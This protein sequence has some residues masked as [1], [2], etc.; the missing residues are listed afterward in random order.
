MSTAAEAAAAELGEL[1]L[2]IRAT[3]E[4]FEVQVLEAPLR[5]FAR[6]RF[7]LPFSQGELR[8]FWK[9]LWDRPDDETAWQ[10]T[11]GRL[12]E[13]VFQGDVGQALERAQWETDQ[14]LRVRLVFHAQDE[15]RLL[16]LVPWEGL[17]NEADRRFLGTHRGMPVVR[18]ID[19]G[20][21]RRR[22]LTAPLPLR[23]LPVV[24]APKDQ[25]E[26]P[27]EIG[28]PALRAGLA[29]MLDSGEAVVLPCPRACQDDLRDA[30]LDTKPH[31]L[32]FLGHGG[33]EGDK[34][35]LALERPDGNSDLVDGEAFTRLLQDVPSLRLVVLTSCQTSLFGALPFVSLTAAAAVYTEV[36]A[37]IAMQSFLGFEAAEVFTRTL[38][39][40][41]AARDVLDVAMSEARSAMARRGSQWL[42]PA[43][44]MSSPDGRL[45][46]PRAAQ[47]S[48]PA[49]LS[50][51]VPAAPARAAAK[52]AQPPL[53]LGVRSMTPHS[54]DLESATDRQLSLR[55]FF[56]RRD[57]KDPRL[58]HEAIYPRLSEFLLE[59]ASQHR[60]LELYFAAHH[61][62]TFAAGWVLQ[63][64]SGLDVSFLQGSR[65]GPPEPW[66]PRD[67]SAAGDGPLWLETEET[68]ED[69][70]ASDVAIAM[71]LTHPIASQVAA[72]LAAKGPPVHRLLAAEVAPRAGQQA[73]R[74]GAHCLRLAD[75]IAYQ[76]MQRTPQE[77]RGTLH[78][79]TA[80]PNAF[81]FYLG[82]L[83]R[84]F[85][86]IQLY[87]YGFDETR[88][89]GE[90]VPSLVLPPPGD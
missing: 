84:P 61:T 28:E 21:R 72:H 29:S 56:D 45:V 18:Q 86:R 62:I 43:L 52:A 66:G 83:A 80:A 59:A 33:F 44:F 46:P 11:G 73:I 85:G 70:E 77:R 27:L 81:L 26:F 64:K 76:A 22:E 20:N 8:A 5:G 23:V 31:V 55:E 88:Q 32:H 60:H 82:Q 30:L 53:R 19:G 74:G 40:R 13:A 65:G 50:V 17:W 10:E 57:I 69:P 42:L 38:Y 34:G 39:R 89:L 90:Y 49:A 41:L 6:Q 1:K 12:F 25:A 9:D 15:S 78:L 37:M 36:P 71:S 68:V 63:A 67:G 7:D 47:P 3:D 58:W 2:A 79:F 75:D 48:A 4:G 16:S 24:A 87:E 51:T 35:M 54:P 14:R